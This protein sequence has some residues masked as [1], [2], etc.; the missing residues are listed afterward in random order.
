MELIRVD[1]KRAY[2]D[3]R[4]KIITLE[5]EPGQPLDAGTLA[6]ELNVSLKSVREALRLLVHDHLVEAPPRGLYVADIDIHD[7]EK[8]S[9]IRLHLEAFSAR[10]AAK[11][12]TEDDLVV[13]EALCQEHAEEFQQLLELDHKFHQAIAQAAH[14]KYLAE[15]LEHYFGLSQRVWYLALPHLDFLPGAVETHIE[16]VDAIQNK[17][18]DQA[19]NIMRSHIEEFYAKI[20]KV[21]EKELS[22]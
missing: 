15:A 5:L 2:Q 14:N 19:E 6:E 17:N 12:A 8:I 10:E 18:S 3:I 22:E 20:I 9:D 13:L 21:L 4:E 16:L 1:T 7:L 11:N